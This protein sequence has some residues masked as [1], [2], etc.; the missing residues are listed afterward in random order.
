MRESAQGGSLSPRKGFALGFGIG[1]TVVYF[2]GLFQGLSLG[3][4]LWR[5]GV[6][7]LALGAFGALLAFLVGDPFEAFGGDEGSGAREDKT[8][9]GPEG[10]TTGAGGIAEEGSPEGGGEEA[11]SGQG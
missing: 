10:E 2:V 3:T 4:L 5:S 8:G 9:Q 7:G 11:A 6:G 1:L